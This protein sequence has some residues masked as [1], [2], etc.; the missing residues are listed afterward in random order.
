[1]NKKSE[2]FVKE[3]KCHC[4]YYFSSPNSFFYLLLPTRTYPNI[5]NMEIIIGNR[6]H[7]LNPSPGRNRNPTVYHWELSRGLAGSDRDK[8]QC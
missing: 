4:K 5:L 8:Q 3:K 1:M 2:L 7:S 6:P